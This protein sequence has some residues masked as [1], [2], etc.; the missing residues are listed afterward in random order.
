QWSFNPKHGRYSNGKWESSGQVNLFEGDRILTWSLLNV[1]LKS[2]MGKFLCPQRLLCRIRSSLTGSSLEVKVLSS[3]T[4]AGSSYPTADNC[5][6]G[7][8]RGLTLLRISQI[9]FFAVYHF[10]ARKL[11]N[12]S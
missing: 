9:S 11:K 5:G 3:H 4:L 12:T 7:A 2:I 1:S 6:A 10:R 8:G